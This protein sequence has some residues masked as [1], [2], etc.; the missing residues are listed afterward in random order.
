MADRN[1]DLRPKAV[2]IV[3]AM[4]LK[5]HTNLSDYQLSQLVIPSIHDYLTKLLKSYQQDE[6]WG[7]NT[8]LVL[9]GSS[10]ERMPFPVDM[11]R[12]EAWRDEARAQQAEP[13]E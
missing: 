10:S 4:T 2:T 6:R 11:G 5:L 1:V 12:Y 13:D 8:I 9:H 3:Y 7:D